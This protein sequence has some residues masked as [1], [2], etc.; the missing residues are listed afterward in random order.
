MLSAIRL[1]QYT[2][3]EGG[4]GLG[5]DWDWGRTGTG[6]GLGLGSDW[7][8]DRDWGRTGTGTGIQANSQSNKFLVRNPTC[9][10]PMV[11]FQSVLDQ[12]TGNYAAKK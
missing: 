10:T 12:V 1:S 8:W 2:I 11:L 6:V 7:D 3:P 5:S 4:P 9:E